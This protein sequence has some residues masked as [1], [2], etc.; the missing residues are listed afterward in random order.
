MP[1]C[2]ECGTPVKPGSK[3]CPNCGVKLEPV[4]SRVEPQQP[5]PPDNK[6]PPQPNQIPPSYVEKIKTIIPNL[7]LYKGWGRY[8]TFN[9][10]VTD[11][12][13]IFSKLTNEMMNNTIKARRSKAEGEG[14][15]FFGKWKAQMQNFGSYTDY[16][17]G[18]MPDQILMDS[19]ENYAVDNSSIKGLNIREDS[20]DE[21]MMT[22]Y[23]LEI[24]TTGKKISFKT[25]YD[26]TEA[27]DI[28]YGLQKK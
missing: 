6:T 23:S 28:A 24:L 14:K 26:P 20:G 1:F 22:W 18:M 12:R 4:Q 9:L 15:G 2:P 8:D 11:R 5:Q 19:K 3:F 7:M 21:S 10:I 25:Q 27:F 16:Y 17:E 13:S